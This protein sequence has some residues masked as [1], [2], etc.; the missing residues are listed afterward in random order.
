MSLPAV[1]LSRSGAVLAACFFAAAPLEIGA[2]EIIAGP[3]EADL[4]AA[5]A[6]AEEGDTV[7]VTSN[8]ILQAPVRIAKRLTLRSNRQPNSGRISGGFAGALFE[9]AASGIVLEWLDL[10]SNAEQTDGLRAEAGFL[11]RD[12]TMQLFRRPV[13]TERLTDLSQIIRLE[14]VDMSYNLH[15]MAAWQLEA[16]DCTFGYNGGLGVFAGNAFLERCTFENN[17][18]AGLSLIFGTVR[19]C[20]F[21]FNGGYGLYF[22][23]DPGAM[24]LSASVFYGNVGGGILLGEDA[25]AT[26]DNCTFT[27][28]TGRP[29][30]LV[31]Q[32]HDILFRHCT[33]AD[34]IV[35]DGGGF[36]DGYPPGGAFTQ[37][38]E[39]RV[40]LQNCL[41]ADNPTSESPYAS[42]LVGVW[43]NGGGNV[44][45]GPA[46]LGVLRDNG[47]P[48]PSLV[49]QAGSPA[50]D[51][52]VPSVVMR[53]ARGLSR[54]AGAAPDA[55]AI[56]VNA[57]ELVDTDGDGLPDIWE[58]FRGL[59]PADRTDAA[60]DADGDGKVALDEF[61]SGTDP[62]DPNSF[63]QIPEIS[64]YDVGSSRY[65]A[66]TFKSVRGVNYRIERSTDLQQW[67]RA[68]GGFSS[69][70]MMPGR[71]PSLL[72]TTPVDQPNSFY[73]LV[74]IDN[75]LE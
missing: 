42:D 64:T 45:G 71:I 50:I 33:V 47:G 18:D 60:A 58:I 17:Q 75:P 35:I 31:T 54:Q 36:P 28:H 23:P 24:N 55:G 1:L 14:R 59:D 15:E 30:V 8:I 34:N 22:D 70:L 52:G 41:I 62:R 57:G 49:P 63:L 74:V 9:L 4:R 25:V 40:E 39:G 53:D 68:P 38:T 16:K 19:S 66:L 48:T 61:R 69:Q 21:R 3:S 32:A 2:A 27:R 46:H 43:I 6:A 56:E 13:D 65:V 7:I 37:R 44:I 5:I 26:I 12:C 11:M 73:R 51:A 20:I 10:L 29:A 72:F 67:Q